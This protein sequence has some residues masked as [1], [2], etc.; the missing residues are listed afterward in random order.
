[1]GTPVVPS[2]PPYMANFFTSLGAPVT[3]RQYSPITTWFTV[4]SPTLL[5]GV[6]LYMCG[7]NVPVEM[8]LASWSDD[9]MNWRSITS[10][11]TC[12]TS[13]NI[14]ELV[15]IKFQSPGNVLPGAKYT[16]RVMIKFGNECGY[17]KGDGIKSPVTV[18][19]GGGEDVK[20]FV[21]SGGSVM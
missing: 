10:T 13:S 12:I 16:Y 14:T 20:V 21:V 8:E 5:S 2:D 11:S 9:L 17:C 19:M 6:G 15:N 4:D 1:M 7:E 3:G 18:K